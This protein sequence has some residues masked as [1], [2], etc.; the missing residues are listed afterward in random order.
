MTAL[1]ETTYVR[2]A[3][4][5]RRPDIDLGLAKV[6][7]LDLARQVDTLLSALAS[8][9]RLAEAQIDQLAR[10]RADNTHLRE[11]LADLQHLADHRANALAGVLEQQSAVVQ[12]QGEQNAVKVPRDRLQRFHDLI[13]VGSPYTAQRELRALL[14]AGQ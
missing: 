7:C 5:L 12:E 1:P 2:I 11:Q 3:T 8:S 13:M 9:N 14:E 4:G 6:M 10:L